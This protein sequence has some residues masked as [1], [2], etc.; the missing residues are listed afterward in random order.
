MSKKIVN[1]LLNYAAQSRADRLLI[2]STPDRLACYYHFGDGEKHSFTLPKKLEQS[3]LDSLRQVL[4]IAPG[5]LAVNKYC[6][7]HDRNYSLTFYLTI[8]PEKNGEQVAITIVS[9]PDLGTELKLEKIGL[10]SPSRETI[11][12]ALKKKSGLVIVSAPDGQGKNTTLKALLATLD[13]SRLN[14]YYFAQRP[15]T[16]IAGLNCLKPTEA[17][18]DR[19]LRQD[20]DLIVLNDAGSAD[21]PKALRAA[22]SGRLVMMTITSANVWEAL[23]SVLKSDVPLDLKLNG[24]RLIV[25]QRLTRL[26]R[27][28]LKSQKK[29]EGRQLIGLFEILEITPEMKRFIRTAANQ[30]K[31]ERFWE[32]LTLLALKQ[33]YKSLKADWQKKMAAGLIAPR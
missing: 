13:L 16:S 18:W 22:D 21:I 32:D 19:L 10:D 9:Q 17:N 30:K 28:K 14:G 15:E 12:A 2:E 5:E 11:R 26:K 24:L 4:K 6:K 8:R 33:G 20:S 27:P 23:A 7:V 3:L 31:I 25:N 1:H 29:R